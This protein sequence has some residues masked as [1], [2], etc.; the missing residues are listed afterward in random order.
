MEEDLYR[1]G[2]PKQLN[3][4]FLET[5]KLKKIIYL[6]PDEPSQRLYVVSASLLCCLSLELDCVPCGGSLNFV[7]DQGIELIPLGREQNK[8]P[9]K[10]IS[11]VCSLLWPD[12]VRMYQSM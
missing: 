7:E 8:T 3:F 11:E 6:A 9:W 10:S 12:A 5:L 1:S 2:Q 4:P